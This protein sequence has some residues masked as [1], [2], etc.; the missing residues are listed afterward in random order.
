MLG[1]HSGQSLR[2]HLLGPELRLIFV[3]SSITA[4]AAPKTRELLAY[5]I[6]RARDPISRDGVA[7]MLWPDVLDSVSTTSNGGCARN[8]ARSRCHRHARFAI[9][10]RRVR[11]WG[12]GARRPCE[13]IW[14]GGRANSNRSPG[15]SR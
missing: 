8:S 13:T 5:L 10:L 9:C 4:S 3:G 12:A 7:S 11:R 14:S 6:L 1:I 15:S 2:I